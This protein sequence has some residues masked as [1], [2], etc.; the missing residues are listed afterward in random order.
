MASLRMASVSHKSVHVRV[1]SFSDAEALAVLSHEFL[2]YE[3]S[4]NEFPGTLQPWA[5]SPEELRKQLRHP[6]IRFFVAERGDEI[7]GYLKAV[8]YGRK[9]THQTLP[10]LPWI[11][12]LIERA[13]RRIY[14]RLT[15]RPRPNASLTAGYIAGAYVVPAMRHT[16]IG[17]QLIEAAEEWFYREGLPVSELHVLWNNEAARQFWQQAGY[18]PLVMG[19]RKKL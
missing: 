2:S 15:Q 17:R 18:E 10:M 9:A 13:A 4:L 16:G 14:D 7:V 5:A 19:M 1:A 8:I 6:D 12:S 3:R 11:R